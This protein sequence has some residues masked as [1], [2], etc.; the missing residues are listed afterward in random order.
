MK[1]L[2]TNISGESLFKWTRM[3]EHAERD[4]ALL[5]A[6]CIMKFCSRSSN[7]QICT[8]VILPLGEI[9]HLGASQI[10]YLAFFP[11]PYAP[12]FMGKFNFTGFGIDRF[13]GS[14]T[15]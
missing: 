9:V 1:L 7:I 10:D 15:S 14:V 13:R 5:K 2:S 8:E 11:F 4:Y 3:L 12:T 6:P